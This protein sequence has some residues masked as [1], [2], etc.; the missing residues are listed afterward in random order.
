MTFCNILL[1]DIFNVC[2]IDSGLWQ[3]KY[4]KLGQE[5]LK[6]LKV[7]V[8]KRKLWF[9]YS[10]DRAWVRGNGELWASVDQYEAL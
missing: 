2:N 3:I 9:V 10:L 5:M 6:I 4:K 7:P 8:N 1:F